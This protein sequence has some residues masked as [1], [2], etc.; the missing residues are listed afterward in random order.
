ML[1][2]P[3]D[4]VSKPGPWGV[5]FDCCSCN[6]NPSSNNGKSCGELSDTIATRDGDGAGVEWLESVEAMVTGD[7]GSEA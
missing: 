7:D 4:L 5:S 1:T 6:A 3:G 2:D